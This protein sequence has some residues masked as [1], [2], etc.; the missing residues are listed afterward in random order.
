[1]VIH[2]PMLVLAVFSNLCY[3]WTQLNCKLDKGFAINS[4]HY[5]AVSDE[6][7]LSELCRG[8][9]HDLPKKSPLC[10]RLSDPVITILLQSRCIAAS[11][12]LSRSLC[13]VTL[14]RKV[15]A[16][17]NYMKPQRKFIIKRYVGFRYPCRRHLHGVRVSVVRNR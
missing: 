14:S 6:S 16:I 7:D 10:P 3:H 8:L 11:L 17:S 4:F 12:S 2:I 9:C 5:N 15:L 13:D 1:M